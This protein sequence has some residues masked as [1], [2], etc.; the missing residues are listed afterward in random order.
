MVVEE[1]SLVFDGREGSQALFSLAFLGGLTGGCQV[2]LR[3]EKPG[4][5]HGDCGSY[6][7]CLSFCQLYGSARRNGH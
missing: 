1:A 2:R 5:C 4:G 3:V 7:L 6:V